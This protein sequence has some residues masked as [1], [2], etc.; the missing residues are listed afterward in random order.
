MA[1]VDTSQYATMQYSRTDSSSSI[2]A[3]TGKRIES[4]I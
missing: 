1:V 3:L 2:T 4:N